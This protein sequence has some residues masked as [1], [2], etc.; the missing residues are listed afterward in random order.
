M[1]KKDKP[2]L[3]YRFHNPNPPE[4]FVPYLINVCIEA[5]K[6]RVEKALREAAIADCTEEITDEKGGNI[7]Q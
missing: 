2:K 7:A 5:N 4:V 1:G 6:G 3:N